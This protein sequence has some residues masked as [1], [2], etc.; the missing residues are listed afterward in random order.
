MEVTACVEHR[1]CRVWDLHDKQPVIHV[2]ERVT[3]E[4]VREIEM[5][6]IGRLGLGERIDL[7]YDL[8][9]AGKTYREAI[10]ESRLR[11]SKWLLLARAAYLSWLEEQDTVEGD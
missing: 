10:D 8:L 3:L 9:D 5:R 1:D 11:Q 2:P 4:R 7:M 6:K